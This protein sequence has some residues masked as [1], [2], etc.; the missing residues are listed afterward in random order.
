MCS[1]VHARITSIFLSHPLLPSLPPHI[2]FLV[3]SVVT[4]NNKREENNVLLFSSR[5]KKL[6]YIF[7]W[8]R[9]WVFVDFFLLVYRLQSGNAFLVQAVMIYCSWRQKRRD[10]ESFFFPFPI[11]LSPSPC[12]HCPNQIKPHLSQ[13]HLLNCMDTFLSDVLNGLEEEW[14]TCTH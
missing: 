8:L 4:E 1:L 7:S 10:P 13:I 11:F 5:P 6:G 3:H 12:R 9:F 2:F 14:K